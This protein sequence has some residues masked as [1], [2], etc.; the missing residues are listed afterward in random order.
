MKNILV[1]CTGNSCRSQLMHGYLQHYLGEKAQVYSAG[2]ETHGVNPWAISTM[3]EDGIDISQ[4]TS[5]HVDEYA[6]IQFDT[7]NT[8]CDHAKE[9][10]P[11][12]PGIKENIHRGFTDPSK[13]KGTED[14]VMDE[15][16]KVRDE[17]KS[18]AESFS[19]R[20]H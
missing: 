2:V 16:R 14:Q 10:C 20:L 12:L 15:F 17:I 9:V 19:R 3:D 4:H 18:F 8:V 5:N 1:L 6:D 11:V 7:L 13:A